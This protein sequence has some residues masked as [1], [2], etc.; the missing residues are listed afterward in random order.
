MLKAM[1]ITWAGYH[2]RLKFVFPNSLDIIFGTGISGVRIGLFRSN[3]SPFCDCALASLI[4][5][6]S[7]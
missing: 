1:R 7:P 4:G 6:I 3:E 2:I 5:I